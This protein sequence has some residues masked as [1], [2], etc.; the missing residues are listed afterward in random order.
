MVVV[1]RCQSCFLSFF[2]LTTLPQNFFDFFFAPKP[3][4]PKPMF[5]SKNVSSGR[6]KI[7]QR[8]RERRST[9]EEKK[10]HKIKRR[11]TPREHRTESYIER[12]HAVVYEEDIKEIQNER[13]KRR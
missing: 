10:E 4:N 11:G 13:R 2:F 6:E 3:L 12:T 1:A 7:R 5:G 8:E 9:Q